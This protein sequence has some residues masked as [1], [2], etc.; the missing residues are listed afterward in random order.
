VD[1]TTSISDS[2]IVGGISNTIT[3]P[4]SG[5]SC[6]GHV[7]TGGSTNTISANNGQNNGVIM[8][9]NANSMTGD[10]GNSV[11]CGAA[12][13]VTHSNAFLFSD[14]T[15][16]SSWGNQTFTVGAQGG[17]IFYSNAARTIGVSLA[18]GANSWAIVSD[19]NLKENLVELNDDSILNAISQIG[20]YRYNFIGCSKERFC[21]GPVAQEW[22][23]HFNSI[24]SDPSSE[25]IQYSKDPLRIDQ[26]DMM[27][28][29]LSCIKGLSERVE[30][31]S[32]DIRILECA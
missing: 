7:I 32:Q 21:Y 13:S 5:T 8:G 28:I 15:A 18:A 20:V 17:S 24:I 22:N 1:A 25:E 29:M 10:I 19:R 11:C 4:T 3:L 27:G 6:S 23:A 2:A 31:L 12:C 30:R 26:G 9:G 16:T 14:G